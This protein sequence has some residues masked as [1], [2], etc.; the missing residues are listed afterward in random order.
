MVKEVCMKKNAYFKNV[1]DRL[2]NP[3]AAAKEGE[4][5]NFA[6]LKIMEYWVRILRQNPE[7]VN[8][9]M[10]LQL[11]NERYR[12]QIIQEVIEIFSP[13]I[14]KIKPH[15]KK[16]HLPKSEFDD[17]FLDSMDDDD[18]PEVEYNT[19]F[20][21]RVILSAISRYC[22]ECDLGSQNI[23]MANL[24]K[25]IKGA[26][27]ND[28]APF[29]YGRLQ[30]CV[31]K[32]FREFAIETMSN[33]D[34][35]KDISF[36]RM[37]K[38]REIYRMNES[39]MEVLIYLWLRDRPEMERD[40][41][42]CLGLRRHRFGQPQASI[43]QEIA[44]A[45]G[46]STAK[47]SDL[48]GSNS[49]LKKLS[50]FNDDMD[51]PNEVANFLNGQSDAANIKA[52][53]LAKA[54]T[55]PFE[56]LKS[57]NP[58]AT[59]V[60]DMIKNHDHKHPLNIL[61]YGVEG[62]GK[63]ELAKA[64][65]HEAGLPLWE[66]SIAAEDNDLGNRRF[67]S[68]AQ[69]LLQ[70]RM[71]AAMLADWQCEKSPGIIMIDEADLVLNGCEKGSLNH[72]F[73]STHTPI[74]WITNSM[75]F[76]ERSTCRRFDFSLPFKGLAK[77]ERLN[78][79]NSV[80]KQQGAADLFTEEEKLRLVVEYPAMAGGFSLAAMRTREL[81]EKGVTNKPYATMSRFLKAH[82]QL[83][84]IENGSLREVESH[85]P[86]YSL[87][88]LNIEGSVS[89]IM[90]VVR[91]FDGI[92]KG[93]S[94]DDGPRSLNLLLYGP[95]GT[96]KTEFVRH[97]AR[98]LGRNL[99]VRRAS[100]LL[101]M[102]VGQTEAQIAEAFEEAERTK[103]ILFFDEADSFLQ[104][105]SGAHQNHEVSK[106]NEIL[107]RMENFKGIFI[108]ATNFEQ[109]LDSASRR[110]FAM[111]LGFGYL[112]PEGVCEIWKA[113]FPNVEC[114]Q[115]AMRLPMLTPG[116]FNAVNGRL[117]YLPESIRTAERIEEELRKELSAKDARAGRTMGF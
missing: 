51:I 83:L 115:S 77:D 27:A 61:F 84:G 12:L 94:E 23:A 65:A 15:R 35:G 14:I 16:M 59:L 33:C 79:F 39:E 5:P 93:L 81:V 58:D 75:R 117:C 106:V 30:R 41:D 48:L 24:L 97:I 102:Y 25:Q 44:L 50:L 10:A 85:A 76:V 107:T 112:K 63:T 87:A 55:V 88:G 89:E 104:D 92:W 22:R 54:G 49:T 80:L 82:T 99:I 37:L 109:T 3:I 53:T 86:R 6:S 34:M 57:G 18:P 45:T 9:D 100:D 64:I 52:F 7:A 67:E 36:A 38:L 96:G 70:Y 31:S 68:R 113:F 110:R 71:R 2:R 69:S 116:D 19:K 56:Q 4:K 101:G 26:D 111:K 8:K 78:M 17:E 20:C 95:P 105:R 28:M 21:N 108:A 43:L 62:A 29:L 66:V 74:I 98:T 11:M 73:E 13:Y 1:A 32:N 90:D 72:F 40:S 46:F 47:V 114:P 103:S 60:L 42:D 91:S